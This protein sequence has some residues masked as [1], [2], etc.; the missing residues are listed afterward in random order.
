MIIVARNTGEL[1]MRISTLEEEKATIM[2]QVETLRTERQILES[3]VEQGLSQIKIHDATKDHLTK[4]IVALRGEIEKAES[5]NSHLAAKLSS[6]EA[7]V[8]QMGSIQEQL[9][10]A[11]SR[12]ADQSLLLDHS[13]TLH[14]DTK[15]KEKLT[16]ELHEAEKRLT[17]SR[18]EVAALHE[19][20]LA[21][22][23]RCS[24]LERQVHTLSHELGERKALEG[25]PLAQ[26]KGS[27]VS[28]TKRDKFK[29]SLDAE[30]NSALVDKEV[31]TRQLQE[32]QRRLVKAEGE[33]LEVQ[34]QKETCEAEI[35]ELL[36]E[37]GA[38]KVTSKSS[39]GERKALGQEREEM[40]QVIA[41]LEGKVSV[42]ESELQG[43]RTQLSETRDRVS[44]LSTQQEELRKLKKA[45][46]EETSRVVA[47]EHSV[48]FLKE[49]LADVEAKAVNLPQ[50]ELELSAAADQMERYKA[51]LLEQAE[52]STAENISLKEALEARAVSEQRQKRELEAL[53][54]EV[55][56]T[57]SQMLEQTKLQEQ[58]ASVKEELDRRKKEARQTILLQ[59]IT[60]LKDQ[61]EK[62][63]QA[64]PD[65]M[66][67]L[68]SLK[69]AI[70][71]KDAQEQS[72]KVLLAEVASLKKDLESA[73][74][75]DSARLTLEAKVQEL[76][77]QLE[78]RD[79][80]LVRAE[81]A[82]GRLK[83]EIQRQE[84]DIR[85][86]EHER[87]QLENSLLGAQKEVATQASQFSRREASLVTQLRVANEQT[88]KIQGDLDALHSE[89]FSWALQKT[90]LESELT[91]LRAT[92]EQAEV[93]H[94]DQ[95]ERAVRLRVKG[96]G[97]RSF[98]G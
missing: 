89:S 43:L 94:K 31:L 8:G 77:A 51:K 6:T 62:N 95:E 42:Y 65:V 13:D 1:A 67:E 10:I 70:G 14:S 91:V 82:F 5:K 68:A 12:L 83:E 24:E 41:S 45:L 58:L 87:G 71:S 79:K 57:R 52:R 22:K 29:L 61:V 63:N 74:V 90:T 38:L 81:A 98:V 16:K 32:S 25:S 97:G 59:E 66:Q 44:S 23:T 39:D 18:K 88:K 9:R 72:Q 69:E 46:A 35:A 80:N 56:S 75:N 64:N 11:N 60:D 92:S 34:T 7:L 93:T 47:S 78:S 28:P 33:L 48:T 27:P 76:A 21:G 54:A 40:G 15:Q 55:T 73:R 17:E 49:R 96:S 53:K 85:Q 37:N 2:E 36:K 20:A 19:D 4:E 3:R 86:L 30:L 26:S 50:L 84:G